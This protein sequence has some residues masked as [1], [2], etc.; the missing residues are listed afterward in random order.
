MKLYELIRLPL[1]IICLA[2]CGASEPKEE[3]IASV[4]YHYVG[5]FGGGGADIRIYR[6]GKSVVA[7]LRTDEGKRVKALLT[8]Q[9]ID[10]LGMFVNAVKEMPA[11]SLYLCTTSH[12]IEVVYKNDT[13]KRV[14]RNCEWD[15]FDSLSAS[16]FR[17][18]YHDVIA[19]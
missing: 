1:F 17:N 8:P 7:E 11:E 12:H 18:A 10:T 5:C 13:T 19:P 14:N 6:S 15:G 16:L 3:Q 9:Q 2:G 4:K